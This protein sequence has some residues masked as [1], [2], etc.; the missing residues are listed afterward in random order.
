MRASMKAAI[1]APALLLWAAVGRT[2]EPPAAAEAQPESQ[3]EAPKA[4]IDV[5]EKASEDAETSTTAATESKRE[6][7]LPPGFK[8][9]KRGKFVVYCKK[10]AVLGT[11]MAAERCYDE[12]G[13]RAMLRAQEED[14]EKVDQMRRI[15]GSMESCGGGG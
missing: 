7:V 8:P 11:R 2:D 15:C 3:A 10:D 14:R 5:V 6:L 1:L 9:K 12:E 13:I 4:A